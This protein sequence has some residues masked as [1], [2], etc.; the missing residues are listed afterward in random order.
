LPYVTTEASK[1]S[2]GPKSPA[3]RRV[4]RGWFI[5]RKRARNKFRRPYATPVSERAFRDRRSYV[6]AAVKH[7]FFCTEFLYNAV[8]TSEFP[9]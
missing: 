2:P 4:L 8:A 9:R 1:P 3:I 6:R 7:A 5:A